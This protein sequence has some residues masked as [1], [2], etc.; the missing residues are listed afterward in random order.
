MVFFAANSFAAGYTCDTTK[1][2]TTCNTD[3]YLSSGSCLECSPKNGA[4]TS[5]TVDL[6]LGSN[7]SAKTATCTKTCT[8]ATSGSNGSSQ[9]CS[10]GDCSYSN[11]SCTCKSGYTENNPD[12]ASCSCSC[13]TLCTAVSNTTSTQSCERDC[14]VS[15]GSCYYSGSKQT[16]T[17][18]YTS[19]GCSSAGASCSG[20]SAWGDCTG[21]ERYITCPALTYWNG[22]SCAS[23]GNGYICPGFTD[24]KES[25]LSNGY[26]RTQC[27]ASYRDGSAVTLE[28]DC[29]GA[30]QKSGSQETPALPTGWANRTLTD[31][32]VG[33]CT[34]YKKYSGTVT[35]DCTPD[36]CTKG[37][38]CTSAVAG[39]YLNSSAGT[40]DK[41]DTSY[42]SS[43]GG[44][45]TSGYCYTSCATGYSGR[46]YKS[47]TDT[48]SCNT[49]C[50]DKL[51]SATQTCTPSNSVANAYKTT[52]PSGTQT[53]TGYYTNDACSS[54]G[55]TCSGCTAWGSCSTTCTAASCNSG[56]YLSSG[57]CSPCDTGYT[58]NDGMTGG[59]NSCYRSCTTSDVA[60][61]ASV[62]G[63]ITYGGTSGC[64]ATSCKAGYYLTSS[65]T[66]SPCDTGYT[67][68][69]GMT[70]GS[71]ACYR[72]CTTSD[73]SGAS[74]VSGYIS[75]NGTTVNSC[76]A[77]SC[78]S[79]Y[80][81][82]NGTCPSCTSNDSTYPLS[83]GGTNGAAYCFRNCTTADVENSKTVSGTVTKA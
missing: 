69:S 28:A 48:C 30:F 42:P 3:Y 61:S 12:S 60:N 55:D 32:Q 40:C 39:Y 35:Q 59:R 56:Y 38:T 29:L 77:T 79:S 78:Q 50:K 75:K 14:S 1:T 49:L 24:V 51:S 34:Y 15:G 23:C 83:N 18:K 73:V 8:G 45:V 9:C 64:K 27:P 37:Q 5:S 67:S 43:D 54:A 26:G 19:D 70:G 44:T 21:G 46:N 82:S 80:Y 71:G 22:S 10:Y 57:A 31:C 7:M 33:T 72:A 41:C 58:S 74:A 17:G 65:G 53:C 13:T 20:C 47:A 6:A 63:T 62:S 36:N 16:C 52:C 81:Y 2:Y 76:K 68:D 66:C 11:Y 25:S 4:T